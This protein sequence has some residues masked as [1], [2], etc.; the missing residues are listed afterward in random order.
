MALAGLKKYNIDIFN[1][2]LGEH[3]YDFDFK[4]EFFQNFEN[5]LI[6]NGEGNVTINLIKSDTFLEL[7]FMIEGALELV[8]DRSLDTF[9]YPVKTERKLI[10]TYGDETG[11]DDDEI[12]FIPWNSQKVNTGQYIYEFLT[13]EV[14]MKKLH[15]RFQDE[16]DVD[17]LEDDLIFSSSKEEEEDVRESSDPRW[18]KLKELK[19]DNK[20]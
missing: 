12:A 15:P 1:L 17:N 9:N 10:L 6:E 18:S 2:P 5:S 8:C 13:L 14:P 3:E 16:E 4:S 20:E 11:A 19:G 7:N